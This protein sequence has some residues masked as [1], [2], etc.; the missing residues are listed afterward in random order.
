MVILLSTIPMLLSGCISR[1]QI[2]AVIFKHEKIPAN[3]CAQSP[4]LKKIGV[5]RIFNCNA[6]LVQAGICAP[7]QVRVRE[8]IS[9]CTQ[10]IER[11]FSIRNDDLERILREAGVKD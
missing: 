6:D 1:K 10:S 8:R 5:F 3:V 9:Y 2:D 4:E 7:G 11:Y